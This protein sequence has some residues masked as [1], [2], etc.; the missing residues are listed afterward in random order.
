MN[1]QFHKYQTGWDNEWSQ[2]NGTIVLD[3]HA[4]SV[5]VLRAQEA[6][7]VQ[8]RSEIKAGGR[9]VAS[10]FL[11]GQ[12]INYDENKL[13]ELQSGQTLTL[14]ARLEGDKNQCWNLWKIEGASIVL[15]N[16][17]AISFWEGAHL[18]D[19]LGMLIACENFA[20]AN[21]ILLPV[22]TT[23]LFQAIY[24]LFKFEHLHLV[25]TESAMLYLHPFGK[26]F[27]HLG[28]VG[29]IV[30]VIQLAT[31]GKMPVQLSIPELRQKEPQ[32]FEDVI[33]CQFD[34]RSGGVWPKQTILEFLRRYEDQKLVI[35]GG[36]DTKSYLG[37]EFEYRIGDLQFL[38]NQLLSCKR[39]VGTDSGLAHL[40]SI[41][42]LEIDLLPSPLV[43]AK[44]VQGI[45]SYYPK[46]PKITTMKAPLNVDCQ[47]KRLLLVSTT[48]GWN[49]GDDLIRQGVMRLLEVGH[50]DP[51]I[52]L[53][54]AQVN[55]S[56]PDR[57][58]DW[59]PLWKKLRNFGDPISLV[60][61]AK[62]LVVAGT[63]EWIDTI[64]PYYLMAAQTGLPIYIIGVGG[65]QEGQVHHLKQSHQ[66]N[67]IC[68]ATVR[69]EAAKKAMEWA[70]VPATRFLDPAFHADAYEPTGENWVVFNPRLQCQQHREFYAALY[71][72]LRDF[73]DVIT[74]HE[75]EE[76]THACDLFDKPIFFH[77]D[78]RPY[79]QLYRSCSTYIGGRM[80]G[81][82][83]SMATGAKVHLI[84]HEQ[85][86]WECEWLMQRLNCPEALTLWDQEKLNID[87]LE[88]VRT[89]FDQR[90]GI[91]ADFEAHRQHLKKFISPQSCCN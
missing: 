80:H 13:V 59:T 65:G 25:P 66:E 62:A 23:P 4:P 37:D 77:S 86:H 84:C 82:I 38:I 6:G 47:N 39:F 76:Y 53:N 73:I 5:I 60:A 29:G 27:E 42:G 50:F 26:D 85:K 19:S 21:D 61:Q 72:H 81:A 30:K 2:E 28:W 68:V 22:R 63:P 11:N 56:D 36:P 8:V 69:D 67:P 24:D 41:L 79:I 57:K 3:G 10:P 1:F 91:L 70:G 64:Q 83:P 16:S 51:V 17:L 40:A 54:R 45:F 49:L 14:E 87:A 9:G 46:P 89:R 12:P 32:K 88:P 90:P 74:V 20:R 44:L 52:W 78:Y 18:G 15:S 31:G 55:V 48:N 43:D 71:K 34:G 75:Q 35:L 58:C 33:L 7:T